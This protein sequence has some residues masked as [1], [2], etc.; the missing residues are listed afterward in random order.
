MLVQRREQL[1]LCKP[2]WRNPFV[3]ST[4]LQQ[5]MDTTLSCDV[6]ASTLE[7]DLDESETDQ[8][9]TEGAIL[10]DMMG[11]PLL[12]RMMQK[13]M[14]IKSIWCGSFRC[15]SQWQ[16]ITTRLISHR[17]LYVWTNGSSRIS[18]TR[19]YSHRRV[20]EHSLASC[21]VMVCP[22]SNLNFKIS[23]SSTIR[24]HC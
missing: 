6:D 19:Q 11:R 10:A 9:D 23:R 22:P 24:Q 18:P 8:A 5:L 17:R 21:A 15:V 2:R 4:E 16:R 20:M 12:M 7:D 3:R 13:R 1:L 14:L